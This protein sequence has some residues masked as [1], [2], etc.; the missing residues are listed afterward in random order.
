MCV[1]SI[2]ADFFTQHEDSLH[3]FALVIWVFN[4]SLFIFFITEL[5]LRNRIGC[6]SI[7]HAYLMVLLSMTCAILSSTCFLFSNHNATI[8]S[9]APYIAISLRIMS[10]TFTWG[11]YIVR[12][13]LVMESLENK[14]LSTFAKK[15]PYILTAQGIVMIGLI[16]A[17]TK[18]SFV[19]NTKSCALFYPLPLLISSALIG[20]IFYGLGFMFI[21]HQA[22][23]ASMDHVYSALRQVDIDKT[24]S[25]LR[26]HIVIYLIQLVSSCL[27]L[28]SV[29]LCI[30]FLTL[31]FFEAEMFVCNFCLLLL[32]RRKGEAFKR[33]CPCNCRDQ[34]GLAVPD[35]S[36]FR[37]KHPHYSQKQISFRNL[38]NTY[39]SKFIAQYSTNSNYFLSN[40]W[41]SDK[42]VNNIKKA[43]DIHR[44]SVRFNAHGFVA[45]NTPKTPGKDVE[46]AVPSPPLFS[47]SHGRSVSATNLGELHD[48]CSRA[49]VKSVSKQKRR[50]SV[51]CLSE[52]K[53]NTSFPNLRSIL[54]AFGVH[55]SAS[56]SKQE[57][58][59]TASYVNRKALVKENFASV[60][61]VQIH[62]ASASKDN[63]YW[64]T[65]F[66]T[67]MLNH[68]GNCAGSEK[69]GVAG[70]ED[71]LKNEPETG[72][73][74]NANGQNECSM[75]I[76][77]TKL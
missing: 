11:L 70:N 28:F 5:H 18:T 46:I 37:E 60:E 40:K 41:R 72:Y 53:E 20:E 42:E 66:A 45:M 15:A 34:N 67:A 27:F 29:S 33:L 68:H 32:F 14:I 30:T 36:S 16:I 49:R 44:E 4:I 8:C 13:Q 59:A 21:F 19:T 22:M 64:K 55:C 39:N 6:R 73:N 50:N 35:T 24:K 74:P 12:G 69:R 71:T 62:S 54:N 7:G 77:S 56:N 2:F 1:H 23:T 58:K 57:A 26:H 51:Q 10:K 9:L 65:L 31:H 63:A 48:M 3:Q 52:T 17:F 75:T 25:Y 38:N 47:N 76:Q 61:P 43:I